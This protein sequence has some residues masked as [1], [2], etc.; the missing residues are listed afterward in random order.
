[1]ASPLEQASAKTIEEVLGWVRDSKGFV[2]DQA[3]D[4]A[5]QYLLWIQ[6][7]AVLG[8][9][10]CFTV[11]L[12]TWIYVGRRWDK[13]SGKV[14]DQDF[15]VFMVSICGSFLPVIFTC[16]NIH[17]LVKCHFAPKIVL[18]EGLSKLF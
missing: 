7:E 13:E 9:I 1:M 14:W 4:I 16:G 11:G 2:L 18:L 3:P 10:L 6:A 15:D 17:T 12:A 8:L 5:Q